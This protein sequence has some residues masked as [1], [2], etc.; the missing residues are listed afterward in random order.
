MHGFSTHDS[1][2]PRR[3][4]DGPDQICANQYRPVPLLALEDDANQTL[5]GREITSTF[6]RALTADAPAPWARMSGGP[7]VDIQEVDCFG[8]YR[9]MLS[10]DQPA[11]SA[12]I[13][14]SF[15]GWW[16]TRH[17]PPGS[18]LPRPRKLFARRTTQPVFQ[19]GHIVQ[20]GQDRSGTF[21]DDLKCDDSQ[22]ARINI[23]RT[24]VPHLVGHPAEC[25]QDF[26]GNGQC[27][28]MQ[29]GL[30]SP[31][32][33]SGG[34][35][36]TGPRRSAW[37]KELRP[38]WCQAAAKENGKKQLRTVVVS[39]SETGAED[40][41]ETR[42]RALRG[43]PKYEEEQSCPPKF[44]TPLPQSSI[45]SGDG[46][47]W[48]WSP[49]H[50]AR[51]LADGPG[52]SRHA[53]TEANNRAQVNPCPGKT[54]SPELH[55]SSKGGS[56]VMLRQALYQRGMRVEE[57]PQRSSVADCPRRTLTWRAFPGQANAAAWAA[58]DHACGAPLAPPQK[59]N[60]VCRAKGVVDWWR[61]C[62]GSASSGPALFPGPGVRSV[63]A[64]GCGLWML[65]IL[66]VDTPPSVPVISSH[67][68]GIP[69]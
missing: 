38:P 24:P 23:K 26:R 50:L 43:V 8:H 10:P 61:G 13:G 64:R 14:A 2:Q 39:S 15:W 32:G 55:A 36:A 60:R 28:L 48:I 7:A 21:Q 5:V 4:V 35:D 69:D 19:A 44:G 31:P 37:S 65:S 47:P 45:Q 57:Q 42:A 20:L 68:P 3:L 56:V 49:A 34:A 59:A 22:S 12:S 62:P 66:V 51:Q 33:K 25:A 54:A 27:S 17:Q 18:D 1:Q 63:L 40:Q 46:E 53:E 16:W 30:S 6:N 41:S 9:L 58:S 67:V 52:R 29:P 11:T